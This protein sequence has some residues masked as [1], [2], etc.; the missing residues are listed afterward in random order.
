MDIHYI[1][2]CPAPDLQ[3]HLIHYTLTMKREQSEAQNMKYYTNKK[4]AFEQM[5]M[6][7]QNGG[8]LNLF[9]L[10]FQIR[11]NSFSVKAFGLYIL[12]FSGYKL[13][14]LLYK[15]LEA[16]AL[17]LVECQQFFFVKVLKNN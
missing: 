5:M 13:L 3:L 17:V 6:V 10:Q 12:I 1:E 11:M 16:I 7:D 14:I 8:M 15:T 2:K 4:Y 9:T